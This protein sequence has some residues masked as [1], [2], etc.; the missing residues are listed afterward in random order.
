MMPPPGE[1]SIR[2][3][4]V[5]VVA[6]MINTQLET[7]AQHRRREIIKTDKQTSRSVL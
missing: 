6:R 1:N 2:V 4:L 5:G 3:E 7:V